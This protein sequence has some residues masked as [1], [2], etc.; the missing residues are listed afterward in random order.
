MRIFGVHALVA[1]AARLTTN[2][3]QP[4]VFLLP[5]NLEEH[6]EVGRGGK[7]EEGRSED[8][9]KDDSSLLPTCIH[10]TPL[11][12]GMSSKSNIVLRVEVDNSI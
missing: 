5:L 9:K 4:Q 6:H 8:G 10:K 7:G 2:H 3:K 11:S 12:A 1:A